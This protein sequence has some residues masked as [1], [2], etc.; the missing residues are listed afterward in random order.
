MSVAMLARQLETHIDRWT[1]TSLRQPPRKSSAKTTIC[2]KSQITTSPYR[3]D[4]QRTNI[5]TTLTALVGCRRFRTTT[6]P[7]TQLPSRCHEHIRK[8]RTTITR[9]ALQ[10]SRGPVLRTPPLHLLRKCP[11]SLPRPHQ[12]IRLS[13]HL[14]TR[15]G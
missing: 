6:I 2:L 13:P 8:M 12:I 9:I 15:P 14:R 5:I 7:R 1:S 3:R 4:T 11:M 10:R